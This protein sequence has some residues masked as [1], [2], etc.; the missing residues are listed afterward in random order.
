MQLQS[1]VDYHRMKNQCIASSFH[2]ETLGYVG[3]DVLYKCMIDAYADHR[4]LVLSPDMIWL[5]LCQAFS[6]HIKSN[7]EKYRTKIVN[8][9]G[10]KTLSVVTSTD[11]FG[12][13]VDWSDILD[14]FYDKIAQNTKNNFASIIES[15][16]STTGINE[17]IAS[18]ITLMDITKHFFTFEILSMI[19]GIPEITLEGKTQDWEEILN[20]IKIFEQFGLNQWSQELR[21]IILEFVNTAKGSPNAKFWRTMIKKN[22]IWPLIGPTCSL[23]SKPTKLD[24][25]FLK[26]FPFDHDGNRTTHSYYMR[27]EMLPEIVNVSVKYKRAN[28]CTMAYDTFNLEFFSGFVG[29]EE[30][31]KTK[32]LRPKIGW[33]VCT[34]EDNAVSYS[35]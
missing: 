19:C 33:M 8:H 5:V 9:K 22:H 15:S 35:Q 3:S 21:P 26:F 30:N 1:G 31:P 27:T 13:N 6:H 2:N 23:W 16:F 28:P 20:K 4:P 34:K 17:R 7:P 25:W 29:V 10:L 24:G 12:G 18:V 11:L 14:G 32:A